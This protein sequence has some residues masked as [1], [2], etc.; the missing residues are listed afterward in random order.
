MREFDAI[1]AA[2]AGRVPRALEFP[3]LTRAAVLIP[4]L[5]RGADATVVFTLRSENVEHHKGEISF[6][7][8]RCEEG[9]DAPRAALREA[10]EE[11]GLD[12][13]RVEIAGRLDDAVSV[14][15]YAVTP[16]VGLC[17][18]PPERCRAQESEVRE[19][20]E[21]PLRELLDPAR[22]R[23]EWRD[24]SRLPDGTPLEALMRI[25]VETGDVDAVKG[26]Y[27][28]LSFDLGPGRVVWGLTARI[29]RNFLEVAFGFATGR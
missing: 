11:I 6:P 16:V 27:R 4:V 26:R 17:T 18:D 22:F 14:S 28:A 29:L 5:R 25:A 1:R 20:F 12:P 10:L 3:E 2:L 15:R 13:A 7:G 8:G 24:V 23:S 21:V 19:V 9:E